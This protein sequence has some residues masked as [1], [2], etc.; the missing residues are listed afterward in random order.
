MGY[1]VKLDVFE[2][3]FDLLVY[4]IERSK[5]SIYDIQ[6]SKITNQY[7]EYIK[8]LQEADIELAQEF[9]VLAAELIKIKS[10]MLLPIE[11]NNVDGEEVIE[12]PRT[13]LVQKILEYKAYKEMSFFFSE[14]AELTSHIHEKPQEDLNAYIGETEEVIHGT[15]DEFAQAFMNFILRKK[16]IEDMHKVYER[17]ERQKMS[18]ERRIRQVI[19]ELEKREETSF[20][21]L[22]GEDDTNFNKVVTFMS[23]LELL[24]QKSITA[25]QE[26]RFG[27]ILIKKAVEHIDMPV[28]EG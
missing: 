20:N 27:D 24:K 16:K 28:E 25:K 23:V 17:I 26:K 1:K 5:M 18:M 22:I 8:K 12:D 19:D 2:G 11:V 3:P 4:L 13:E 21:E 6:I 15:M 9:M 7:L 14:Q 10:R